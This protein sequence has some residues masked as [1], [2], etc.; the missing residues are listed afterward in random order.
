[1]PGEQ[2]SG[3]AGVPPLGHG[4]KGGEHCYRGEAQGGDRWGPRDGGDQGPHSSP[5]PNGSP[6]ALPG[7]FS[8]ALTTPPPGQALKPRPPD[9]PGP[10]VTTAS[11]PK[12]RGVAVD[13]WPS[14]TRNLPSPRYSRGRPGE[15][16]HGTFGS[17]VV[18]G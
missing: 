3:E 13:T 18:G 5:A 16:R 15:C 12:G 4:D 9:P 1:M 11:C 10:C 2:R 17:G 7:A 6:R 8:L 14:C